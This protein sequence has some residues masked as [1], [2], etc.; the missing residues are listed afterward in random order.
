MSARD[1]GRVAVL[2]GGHAEFDGVVYPTTSLLSGPLVQLLVHGE[3]EPPGGF[4][5][6]V[7]GTWMRVVERTA[8]TRLLRV[9]TRA[10]WRGHEVRVE[11]VLGHE[12]D[13]W[14]QTY[15]PPD[16]PRVVLDRD[17]WSATV[18][19]DELSDVVSTTEE[20]SVTGPVRPE[21]LAW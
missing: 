8:L 2:A 7:D 21:G 10:T 3:A 6:R 17:S 14:S 1:G 9:T 20:L 4:Q 19:V 5:R 16:D 15:R 18:P 12:A 13:L 11:R